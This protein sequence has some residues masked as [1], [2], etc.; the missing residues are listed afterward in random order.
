MNSVRH[1]AR[2][3]IHMQ[4]VGPR[5]CLQVEQRFV[6]IDEKLRR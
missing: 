2:R 4:K 3:R 5:D 1:G 6:A